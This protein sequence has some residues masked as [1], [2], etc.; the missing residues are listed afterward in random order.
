MAKI[1]FPSRPCP[2]CGKPIHIKSKS[3]D[4]GWVAAGSTGSKGK[5]GKAVARNGKAM[6]KREAVRQVLSQS[7]NDTKPLDIQEQLKR[8]FQIKMDAGTISNYK[9]TIL[10]EGARKKKLGRPKGTSSII[11]IRSRATASSISIEDIKT[12]KELAERI[13]VDRLRQLAEVLTK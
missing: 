5:T 12:V 1:N 2:K 4:C 11:P 3:H 8:R 7:G 9:S 10:R 6:S 13:G